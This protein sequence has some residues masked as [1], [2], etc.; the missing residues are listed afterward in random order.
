VTG[1]ACD[2][3]PHTY[4][5][6][7]GLWLTLS[8]FQ[9]VYLAAQ[10]VQEVREHVPLDDLE[11]QSLCAEADCSYDHRGSWLDRACG[12]RAAVPAS[13]QEEIGLPLC[14]S[15]RPGAFREEMPDGS[16]RALALARRFGLTA[17][18]GVQCSWRVRA[19]RAEQN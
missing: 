6:R 7:I 4:L 12:A 15:E 13:A 17:T 19:G 2:S 9:A 14:A 5:W 16:G 3:G 1:A 11:R 8:M 10:V 18:R